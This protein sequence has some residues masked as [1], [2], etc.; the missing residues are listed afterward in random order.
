MMTCQELSVALSQHTLAAVPVVSQT[1]AQTHLASCRNC[2]GLVESIN[3]FQRMPVPQSL[4]IAAEIAPVHPMPSRAW[5]IAIAFSLPILAGVVVALLNGLAGW[6]KMPLESALL[7]SILSMLGLAALALGFYRQFKPGAREPIAGQAALAV[8][9]AGFV[10]FAS[11]E[12]GWRPEGDS[13]IL[14]AGRCLLMGTLVALPASMVLLF[15]ARKGYAVNPGSASFWTGTLASMAGL[16]ALG[17]HCPNLELSHQFMGHGLMI[18]GS[19]YLVAWMARRLF[20][21]R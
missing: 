14:N 7:F 5:F 11:V 10:A 8:L 3:G 13:A 21:L 18:V 4:F 20:G 12:F 15:W 16:I 9:V 17:L 2:R 1:A 19:S 6:K